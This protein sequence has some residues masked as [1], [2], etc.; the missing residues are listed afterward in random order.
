MHR[1]NRLLLLL[2]RVELWPDVA[3][4]SYLILKRLLLLKLTQRLLHFFR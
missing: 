3:A 4:G 2:P 1:L